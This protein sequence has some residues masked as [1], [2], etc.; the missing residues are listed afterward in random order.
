MPADEGRN[1]T[2][3]H[4]FT[5]QQDAINECD[6]CGRDCREAP[7]AQVD[8]DHEA[9]VVAWFNAAVQWPYKP[10]N[11]DSDAVYPIGYW[12][13]AGEIDAAVALMRSAPASDDLRALRELR[14]EIEELRAGAELNRALLGDPPHVQGRL[15]A[16]SMALNRIDARLASSAPRAADAEHAPGC[17]E[18]VADAEKQ[19]RIVAMLR[20]QLAA[21]EK[22]RDT[23]RDSLARSERDLAAAKL[24]WQA[25][26]ADLLTMRASDSELTVSEWMARTGE[27]ERDRK[28]LR[29]ELAA[30]R[31]AAPDVE[32]ARAA[33]RREALDDLL[34]TFKAM[35]DELWNYSRDPGTE[36]ER[37]NYHKAIG[38]DRAAKVVLQRMEVAESPKPE[39]RDVASAL[40]E[41]PSI[42]VYDGDAAEKVLD[43]LRT[44]YDHVRARD[45]K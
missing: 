42:T 5:P 40:P 6:Y 12:L 35:R 39:A 27:A 24:A 14:N 10:P 33:G 30:L 20:E 28:K 44:L 8:A 29:A 7:A 13:A 1:V 3:D 45:A 25:E 2:K 43:T 19:H 36:V 18:V 34:T 26:R 23:L 15:M 22:E 11:A 32:A 17:A 31:K 41:F 37:G 21:A 38:L 16:Y 9:K 4:E